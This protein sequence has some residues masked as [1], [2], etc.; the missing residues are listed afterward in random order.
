MGGLQNNTLQNISAECAIPLCN[1]FDEEFDQKNTEL[2]R[3]CEN[4][5][6]SGDADIDDNILSQEVPS[7]HGDNQKLDSIPKI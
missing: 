1:F 6:F 2:C 4:L 7:T 3:C 5:L